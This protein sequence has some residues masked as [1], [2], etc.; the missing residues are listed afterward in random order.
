MVQSLRI[1]LDNWKERVGLNRIKEITIECVDGIKN[2]AYKFP[3]T[4]KPV[5]YNNGDKLN[6]IIDRIDY[7]TKEKLEKK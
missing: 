3:D 1:D 7:D 5:I 4:A 2:T 6:K